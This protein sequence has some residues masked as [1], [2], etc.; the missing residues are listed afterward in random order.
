[1][2][3]TVKEDM[4]KKQLSR[5]RHRRTRPSWLELEPKESRRLEA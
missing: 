3:Y 5:R 1:M 2:L 4:V